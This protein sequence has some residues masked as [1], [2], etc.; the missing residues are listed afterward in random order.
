MTPAEF[1]KVRYIDYDYWVE[2]SGGSRLATDAAARLLAQDGR[3][4]APLAGM[5]PRG[6]DQ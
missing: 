5:G 3:L 6:R 4:G 1:S 2:L